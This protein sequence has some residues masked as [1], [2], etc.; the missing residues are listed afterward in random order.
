MLGGT[1]FSPMK[2]RKSEIHKR[3]GAFEHLKRIIRIPIRSQIHVVVTPITSTGT[4]SFRCVFDLIFIAFYHRIYLIVH[5]ATSPWFPQRQIVW[6]SRSPAAFYFLP[7]LYLL[8][9]SIEICWKRLETSFFPLSPIGLS[10][11]QVNVQQR[12]R[13]LSAYHVYYVFVSYFLFL[14]LYLSP[15]RLLWC[16][17]RHCTVELSKDCSWHCCL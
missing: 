17:C 9:L 7:L 6:D 15:L 12:P 11:K 3:K 2:V 10:P 4:S 5:S 16:F 1:P 13:F 14:S 8:S